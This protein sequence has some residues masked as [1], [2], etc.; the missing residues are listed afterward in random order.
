[1]KI[2][3]AWVIIQVDGI[4]PR[5]NVDV[6]TARMELKDPIIKTGNWLVLCVVLILLEEAHC[7][8][9]GG[10]TLV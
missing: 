9:V 5:L 2:Q 3:K 7:S 6:S 8:R 10:A 1:M 4:K